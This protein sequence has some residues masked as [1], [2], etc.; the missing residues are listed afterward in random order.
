MLVHQRSSSAIEAYWQIQ[1]FS[2]KEVPPIVR[3]TD[4]EVLEFVRKTPN[5]IGYVS[6]NTPLGAD[7][8]AVPITGLQE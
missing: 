5:A 8:K 6:Q 7:V 2:G 3:G 4:A 1:I